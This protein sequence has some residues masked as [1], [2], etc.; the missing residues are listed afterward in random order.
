[1]GVYETY[2]K[3]AGS[4]TKVTRYRVL[5]R[6]KDF[7]FDEYFDTKAEAEKVNKKKLI[8]AK[9][10]STVTEPTIEKALDA[11]WRF[12]LSKTK[13][14]LQTKNLCYSVIPN[15]VFADPDYINSRGRLPRMFFDP[16]T[17]TRSIK[18]TMPSIRTLRMGDI[19]LKN[20][21]KK[22]LIWYI[23]KRVGFNNSGVQ[24]STVR[25][26]LNIISGVIDFYNCEA[27]NSYPNVVR[28]LSRFEKPIIK[29]SVKQKITQDQDSK[30]DAELKKFRNPQM[31]LIYRL[32]MMTGLRTSEI[33]NLTWENIDLNEKRIHVLN[34][35]N[36]TDRI[37]PIF[38]ELE[39]FLETMDKKNGKIFSYTKDGF[40][41]NWQKLQARTGIKIR[42]HTTRRNAISRMVENGNLNT[43]QVAHMLEMNKID[44]VES[45]YIADEK[46]SAI[47][48]KINNKEALTT[49][50]I[51]L[52]VG[53]SLPQM[54]AHYASLD[55]DK[56]F[57]LF[58]N[59]L[60]NGEK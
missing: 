48:N 55:P 41:T 52:I 16:A 59:I 51:M 4:R 34:T 7:K 40:K 25:K 31:A 46:I 14:A 2:Y 26:D 33:L 56:L 27:E 22:M 15:V 29:T 60:K 58:G 3:P 54:T 24:N 5:I 39:E 38:N 45:A 13:S 44:Y 43:I 11:Y 19:L 1:M 42:F 8:Q 57:Q 36:G 10:G 35:K 37:F 30:I 9:G 20:F 53:H 50:E 6:K 17:V 18:S 28:E 12:H 21:T 49:E 32:A 23:N 47:R